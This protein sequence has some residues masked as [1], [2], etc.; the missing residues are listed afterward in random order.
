MEEQKIPEFLPGVSGRIYAI[1]SDKRSRKEEFQGEI[2]RNPFW[3]EFE[4]TFHREVI[5]GN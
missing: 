4:I 5:I 2:Y 3:T 1:N